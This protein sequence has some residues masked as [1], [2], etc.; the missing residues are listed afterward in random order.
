MMMIGGFM[1]CLMLKTY[2]LPGRSSLIPI[3]QSLCVPVSDPVSPLSPLDSVPVHVPIMIG[4]R[5][6]YRSHHL[7]PGCPKIF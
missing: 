4:K 1:C 7:E 5:E 2:A 3:D 6:L